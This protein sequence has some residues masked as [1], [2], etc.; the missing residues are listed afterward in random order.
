MPAGLDRG[1]VLRDLSR[2]ELL[3]IV[4]RAGT[5]AVYIRIRGAFGPHLSDLGDERCHHSIC[6]T[7]TALTGCL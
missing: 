7:P 5:G 6:S 2:D 4:G 3:Q 1:G